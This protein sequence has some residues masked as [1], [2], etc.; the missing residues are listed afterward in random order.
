MEGRILEAKLEMRGNLVL[1]NPKASRDSILVPGQDCIGKDLD[2][3][4]SEQGGGV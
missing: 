1:A 2:S 4:T 3:N